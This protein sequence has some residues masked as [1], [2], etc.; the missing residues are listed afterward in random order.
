MITFKQGRVD[1]E[2]VVELLRAS[3][4]NRPVDD[5]NRIR[6]MLAGADLIL[7][8][9]DADRLIG[10]VRALSDFS[11]ATYISEVAVH[12][13]YQRKGIGRELLERVFATSSEARYV[14]HSVE[15]VDGFYERLGFVP[16]VNVYMKPR[17]R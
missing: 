5:M 6:R 1:A 3:G 17:T 2:Q 13:D 8:A 9:W 12:P 11:W 10:L 15:G 14:L 16:L 7:T 4:M